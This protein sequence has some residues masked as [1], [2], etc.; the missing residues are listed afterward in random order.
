MRVVPGHHRYIFSCLITEALHID[1]VSRSDNSGPFRN[2]LAVPDHT[3]I[4]YQFGDHVVID[5]R[6][7]KSGQVL[8]WCPD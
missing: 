8:L 7:A 6:T 1:Q 5:N 3:E 4:A 2:D